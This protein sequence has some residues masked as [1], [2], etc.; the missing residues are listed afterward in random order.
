MLKLRKIIDYSLAGL[1]LGA[2]A[3]FTVEAGNCSDWDNLS[4]EQQ[5]RLEYSYSYGKPHGLGWTMASIALHESHAGKYKVNHLSRDYGLFQINEKN[6]F[7]ILG[8]TSY[9][10]KQ[11]MLTKVIVDDTL[12]AYL[13]LNILHHFQRVHNGDWRKMITSYNIGNKADQ[14]SVRRGDSYYKKIVYNLNILKRCSGFD[15]K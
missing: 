11:E 8:V 10:K 7:N 4:A 1:L 12:S 14:K 3:S 5:Y 13:A 9:W 2:S 6:I 15:R